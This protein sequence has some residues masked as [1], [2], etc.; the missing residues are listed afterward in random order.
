MNTEDSESYRSRKQFF[1][2]MLTIYGR[3]PVLEALRDANLPAYKLHLAQSNREDGIINSIREAAQ[4]RDIAIDVHSRQALSRISR[5]GKQDQGVALD[6]QLPSY[7][8][9]HSLFHS[10]TP[11]RL[12]ALDRITNPQNLGMIIRTL[13]AS[14]MNGLLLPKQGCARL[15][16]LV[17]KASAGTLFTAPIYYCET[18]LPALKDLQQRGFEITILS[19]HASDSLFEHRSQTAS[20]FVLGNESEG[21]SREINALSDRTLAIPMHNGV[22]S[23][24]VAVTAALIAFQPSA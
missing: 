4:A 6:L 17:A 15:S 5:N 13:A 10:E 9:Y 16:P 8:D 2:Q 14:P 20:V 12:L 19:S 21:V 23:L 3:K 11:L 24:N 7:R 1:E 18:L 22:E